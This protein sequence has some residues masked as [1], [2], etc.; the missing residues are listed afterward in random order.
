MR[1][2]INP[3]HA[4]EGK[5]DPGA[6]NHELGIRECDIA[7]TI[8]LFA[9]SFLLLAGHEAR[10]LQSHNLMGEAAGPNITWQANAWEADAF[11]SIHCNAGGG[12]GV[13]TYC[14]DREASCGRLATTVNQSLWQALQGIDPA[15]PNRGVKENHN[16]CVLRATEMPAIL[17]E[18]GFIDHPADA[19][20]LMAEPER[21]GKAIAE[22]ILAW[23][24]ENGRDFA[25]KCRNIP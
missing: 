25:G 10:I 18:T 24:N 12:R 1:I 14:W 7:R 11:V 5:P 8:G 6:V 22:G 13:E 19:R 21:M 2:F 3:G 9:E 17:V 23:H 15:F 20:L 16:L 4:P